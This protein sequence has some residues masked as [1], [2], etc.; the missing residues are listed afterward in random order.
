MVTH[1]CNHSYLEDGD[2]WIVVQDQ[3][4]QKL[5]RTCL[6]QQVKHGGA[7]L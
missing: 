6:N 5:V 4:E 2:G 3:L 1:A 7:H